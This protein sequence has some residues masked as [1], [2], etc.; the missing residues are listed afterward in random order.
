MACDTKRQFI[1]VAA[2]GNNTVEVIDLKNKK[3]VHSI[4]GM[5]EPQEIVAVPAR[6]G[7]EAEIGLG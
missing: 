6:S 7:N 4:K 2:L 1:Y 3:L 5:S